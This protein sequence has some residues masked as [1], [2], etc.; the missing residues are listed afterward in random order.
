MK[1]FGLFKGFLRN[2]YSVKEEEENGN[3]PLPSLQNSSNFGCFLIS[4]IKKMLPFNYFTRG[5]KEMFAKENHHE[6][7]Y[8]YK[9]NEPCSIKKKSGNLWKI[10]EIR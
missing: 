10:T 1:L 6:F 4:F 5:I 9:I 7:K 3:F 2:G 8:D